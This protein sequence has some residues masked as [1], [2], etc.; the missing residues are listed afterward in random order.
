MRL[1]VFTNQFP[2]RVSTF[3][4]RDMR[5]LLEAGIDIDIFS[6][7]PLD[8]ELWN[9]V[10]DILGENVFPR[11]KA[12]HI[13]IMNSLADLCRLVTLGKFA[14]FLRDT[15]AVCASAVRFGLEPL[16]KSIWAIFEGQSFAQ[17]HFNEKYDHILA[18][19]GN[20]TGTCAYICHRLKAEHIPFS[21]FLHAG[22]DLYRTPVY[23]Q[24]KL[25]YADNIITC[26]DFN[27]HYI[28]ECFSKIFHL[29]SDKIFVHHHGL[30]FKEHKYEPKQGSCQ[31]VIAVGNF[32]KRKGFDYLLRAIHEL[33]SSGREVKVELVGS[34]E[35]ETALKQLVNELDIGENVKFRGWLDSNE[36]KRAMKQATILV[37]PSTELGDG[38]PNVIKEAMALGI[39]VVGSRVA[40]IPELLGNGSHGLLVPP[41]DIKGLA[42]GIE[43][44]LKDEKLRGNYSMAA[45]KFVEEKFDLWKNGER[46]AALLQGT[47]RK[48]GSD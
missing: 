22:T 42:L 3:F 16:G 15:A 41:K 8:P 36:V 31:K 2:A 32:G 33:Q 43:K 29:I 26:S 6:I 34:G 27:Y 17:K 13:Q 39:P 4:A 10:P 5:G 9:F 11:H 44:L 21:I 7:H 37:H 24:E 14:P 19:W 35:Q 40:G 1:A 30:D 38:V 46:L 48:N 47:R 45:R 25:V 28:Q 18:Y 12:H 20:Y 23:M